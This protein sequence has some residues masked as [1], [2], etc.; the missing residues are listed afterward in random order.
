MPVTVLVIP[1]YRERDRLPRFL[2]DL[3]REVFALEHVR[4]RVVDDGSGPEQQAWLAGYVEELRR[5]F[6]F[7][8]PAQLNAENRGKGGAV[9]SGWDQAGA[10]DQLGF[11]DAD[12]AVP[13]TEVV[14]ILRRAEGLPGRAVFAV[15][16]GQDNTQV[17]RALHRRIAGSVFRG[18]VRRLFRFPLQDTQCGCKLVPAAD[19]AAV[20]QDLRE[21]RF[22]FDVELTWHLLHR[23][24]T[25]EAVPIHWTESPGSRLRPGSAWQMYQSIRTL[26]RRLGDWRKSGA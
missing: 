22:T 15:R 19:Y 18:M 17:T 14:R 10:V 13:A 8:D 12:G 1:C 6:P 16:T 9:Y 5:E 26:R 21:N 20:R 23:G 24:V 4:L 3:C 25:V 7:L 2:P 11:V